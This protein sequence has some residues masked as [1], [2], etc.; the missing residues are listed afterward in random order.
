MRLIVASFAWLNVLRLHRRY[1]ENL[2]NIPF[3]GISGPAYPTDNPLW[4]FIHGEPYQPT[5]ALTPANE[6]QLVSNRTTWVSLFFSEFIQAGYN[7]LNMTIEDASTIGNPTMY[8]SNRDV[9]PFINATSDRRLVNIS[10][11]S[12]LGGMFT[13][14]KVY[15][16]MIPYGF[17]RTFANVDYNGTAGYWDWFFRVEG[18]S[19]ILWPVADGYHLMAMLACNCRR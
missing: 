2:A 6:Y 8:L 11:D 9:E 16:V 10:L 7:E 14:G 4:N 5:A 18:R 17:F 15:H 1:V 19:I 13:T 12:A 3:P